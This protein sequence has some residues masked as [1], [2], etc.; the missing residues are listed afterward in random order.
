MINLGDEVKDT[1]T[2]YRGIAIARHTYLQGC[3]RISIQPPIDKEGKMPESLT[4]DEPQLEVVKAAKIKR[5][6]PKKDPGG[7]EKYT[8]QGRLDG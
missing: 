1:I 2:G 6:A 7:P 8:D 3:D 4:F 5:T